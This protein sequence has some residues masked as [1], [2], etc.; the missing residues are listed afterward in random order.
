MAHQGRASG[1]KAAPPQ[2]QSFFD[3]DFLGCL[4]SPKMDVEAVAGK[5]ANRGILGNPPPLPLS[6]SRTAAGTDTASPKTRGGIAA[7]KRGIAV[8]SFSGS[9]GPGSI[10]A[11]KDDS[12]G[13]VL[14]FTPDT[15]RPTPD[16]L[17]LT[18]YTLQPPTST[19]HPLPSKLHPPPYTLHPKPDA[20]WRHTVR[21]GREP[22]SRPS[23]IQPSTN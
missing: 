19:L 21:G 1:E 22:R 18:P 17:P 8:A 10:E 3:F 2:E 14:R 7:P 16:T 5:D 11:P 12:V 4:C 13:G 20:A 23:A 6:I 15:R 9:F